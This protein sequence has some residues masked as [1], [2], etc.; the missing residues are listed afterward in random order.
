MRVSFHCKALSMRRIYGVCE[1]SKIIPTSIV[2]PTVVPLA[3]TVSAVERRFASKRPAAATP[4]DHPRP[5]RRLLFVYLPERGPWLV[6]DFGAEDLWHIGNTRRSNL[7]RITSPASS[8]SIFL[9]QR[10]PPSSP[11]WAVYF[12][13]F[14]ARIYRQLHGF[15]CLCF[16]VFLFVA[17][18]NLQFCHPSYSSLFLFLYFLPFSLFRPFF[19]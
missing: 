8:P 15:P 7:L 17:L 3:N 10:Y 14:A 5:N 12:F 2:V 9:R 13:F 18:S 1:I 19:P 11:S 6:T 4:C 16:F